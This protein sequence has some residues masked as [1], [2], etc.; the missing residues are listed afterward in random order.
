MYAGTIVAIA[1]H[2]CSY[3]YGGDCDIRNTTGLAFQFVYWDQGADPT[4][5]STP[6]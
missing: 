4:D 5:L 6:N 3:A 1:H 2:I